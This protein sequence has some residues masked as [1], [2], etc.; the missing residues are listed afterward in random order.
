[1]LAKRLIADR[2]HRELLHAYTTAAVINHS[3][4][5]PEEAVAVTAYMPSHVDTSR[6]E[7]REMTEEELERVSAFNLE[8]AIL[9]V[10]LKQAAER[11]THAG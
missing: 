6:S 2:E 4:S 5:P 11:A 8:V 10:K 9:A 3:F 7:T 1:M